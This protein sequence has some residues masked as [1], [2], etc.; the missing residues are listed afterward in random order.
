MTALFQFC[1]VYL[2]LL[3]ASTAVNTYLH[4]FANYAT[5][6][7]NYAAFI[8]LPPPFL[9]SA[10]HNWCDDEY[11]AR[12]R[13]W[14][15]RFTLISAEILPGVDAGGIYEKMFI[16]DGNSRSS[17]LP[18]RHCSSSR[19]LSDNAVQ[20]ITNWNNVV[21]RGLWEA[22]VLTVTATTARPTEL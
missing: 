2:L 3:R 9:C 5:I 15:T 18:R 10:A 21:P 19:H 14:S 8:P 20:L 22:A 6:R 4:S 16:H 13:T 17:Q 11:T 1:A 12:R 7:H